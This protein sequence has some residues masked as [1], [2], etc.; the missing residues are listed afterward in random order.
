VETVRLKKRPY[1]ICVGC[2]ASGGIP[3]VCDLYLVEA[4]QGHHTHACYYFNSQSPGKPWL[5]SWPF[6]FPNKRVLMQ[7]FSCKCPSWYQPAEPQ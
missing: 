2:F 4:S 5:A 1:R 6:D 7:I 3:P